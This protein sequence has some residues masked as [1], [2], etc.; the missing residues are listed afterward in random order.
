MRLLTP[1]QAKRLDQE[2]RSQYQLS[3]EIMMESAGAFMAAQIETLF[4]S[5]IK[6]LSHSKEKILIVCG[7]GHNGA[8][9]FV[10]ARHL[11]SRGV[12][13]LQVFYT[14]V[15]KDLW[16]EQ[17]ARAENQQI[18]MF[19]ISDSHAELQ[20]QMAKSSIVVDALF[21]IGLSRQLEASMIDLIEIMNK[22]KGAKVA[23]DVPSGLDAE[24]GRTQGAGFRA[25]ATLTVGLGKPGFY[26]CEGPSLAGHVHLIPLSYPKEL[27]RSVATTHFAFDHKLAARTLPKRPDFSHKGDYGRLLVMAGSEGMSGAALL[28]AQGA[29]RVGVGY[30]TIMSFDPALSAWKETPEFMTIENG[31][32]PQ[33]WPRKQARKET[34]F[35]MG[36][37]LGRTEKTRKLL[38]HLLHE[39]FENVLLDADAL[40]YAKDFFP[41]PPSWILTPHLGEAA[42]LLKVS[43]DEIEKNRCAWAMELAKRSGALVLLKGFRTVIAQEDKCLIVLSGNSALAKAGSG[44]VLSGVISGFLAQGLGALQSAALGAYVHGRCADRW[45]K[46]RNDKSALMPS[47]LMKLVPQV[48]SE[49]RG[50]LL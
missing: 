39:K 11:H 30:C 44:D 32:D 31:R 49:M 13:G 12:K 18:S 1:S 50:D 41:L 9:G 10:V 15:G 40:Y 6:K 43:A 8:D 16:C 17:K 47:D 37:G 38:Q 29:S 20:K 36:P 3:D 48:L 26:I 46:D 25:D 2:A 14:G 7:P 42:R 21:G 33:A 19:D 27:I 28:C 34:A 4:F 23:L 35:C 24:T 45:V 22:A 5:E